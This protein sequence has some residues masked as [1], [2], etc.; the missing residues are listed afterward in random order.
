M[1]NKSEFLV[2]EDDLES[3]NLYA[4]KL[5]DF[6]GP[7]DTLCYLIKKSKYS[8]EDVKISDITQQYMEYMKQIDELD[9]ER[10]T[11]FI[12]MA[13]WL[14]EIKSKSLLPKP[15]EHIEDQE[16]PER[17]LKQ[18]LAEYSL[19]KEASLKMKELETVDILYRAPDNLL[20]EPNF[21]LKNMDSKALL[22]ALQRVFLK[23]EQRAE[24]IRE[25]HIVNDNFTVEEKIDLI[26]NLL[27]K[28]KFI[29]FF[30]LFSNNSSKNEIITTFLA[31][32]EL[33]K[34]QYISAHQKNIFGDIILRKN[35]SQD[36]IKETEN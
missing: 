28:N 18:Q 34:N 30:D 22:S 8:I 4:V 7:F 26:K 23:L 16:D 15:I 12:T 11:E 24:H 19:F 14:I 5:K 32:L 27:E 20:S 29:S 3:G 35:N 1:D 33:L 13:S 10:A 25:R 2:E 9:L 17:I 31:I 21:E 36:I 6:D